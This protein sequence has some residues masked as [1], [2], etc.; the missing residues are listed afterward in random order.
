MDPDIKN[1][2]STTSPTVT[3]LVI[4]SLRASAVLAGVVAHLPHT[5][6]VELMRMDNTGYISRE[7]SIEIVAYLE[8]LTS[9][10]AFKLCGAVNNNITPPGRDEDEDIL[11]R[12]SAARKNS[13][14]IAFTLSMGRWTNMEASSRSLGHFEIGF[15]LRI[16][17]KSIPLGNPMVDSEPQPSRETYGKYF[18]RVGDSSIQN[19][20]NWYNAT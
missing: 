10:S 11:E 3:V 5:H 20:V 1:E 19:S 12:W 15:R 4:D 8:N 17:Q 6:S 13:S 9:L 2:D 18:G 7:E 16:A 14:T